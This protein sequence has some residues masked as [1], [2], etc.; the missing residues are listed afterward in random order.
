[1]TLDLDLWVTL[2][3][4]LWVTLDLDLWVTLDITL[5]FYSP[6]YTI[7]KVTKEVKKRQRKLQT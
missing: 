5:G 2:D 4:D 1:M 7:K 3:L 6:C